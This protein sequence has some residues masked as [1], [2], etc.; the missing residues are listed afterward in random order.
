MLHRLAFH[1]NSNSLLMFSS[2]LLLDQMLHVLASLL[3]FSDHSTLSKDHCG[4]PPQ[5]LLPPYCRQHLPVL[6]INIEVAQAVFANDYPF[7]KP[8]FLPKSRTG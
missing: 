6:L 8:S 3:S 1:K 5:A 4:N 2:S 7:L